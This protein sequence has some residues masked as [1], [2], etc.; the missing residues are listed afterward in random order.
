MISSLFMMDYNGE[1]IFNKAVSDSL[2]KNISYK[3]IFKTQVIMEINKKII[4]EID[5]RSYDIRNSLILD[6]NERLVSKD[7]HADNIPILTIGTTTFHH[8]YR[9]GIYVVAVS[10][11][12]A[13]SAVIWN[14]LISLYDILK[15]LNLMQQVM[16][17]DSLLKLM[18]VVNFTLDQNGYPLQNNLH[19]DTIKK[20]LIQSY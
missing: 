15:K 14:Y 4:Q 11:T 20:F 18:N 17:I 12:N 1:T 5:E 7:I 19:I 8:I 9:N 13:E 16:M 3:E 10:Q 6:Y 2:K